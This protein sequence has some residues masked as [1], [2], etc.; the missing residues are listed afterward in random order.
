M[1][2]AL[3]DGDE[4][5]VC[6]GAGRWRSAR[7]G[8]AVEPTGEIVT[9]AR[10]APPITIAFAPVKGDRPEWVVQKLTELGV[11]TIVPL[12]AERSVVVWPRT[13]ESRTSSIACGGSAAKPRCSRGSAT[14][15][16][17]QRPCSF[18]DAV[19]RAGV[20]LAHR[21]AAAPDLAHPTVL[22]GPEGG[23]SDAE[24]AL[25]L[26]RVG[27]GPGVLA[28]GDR[29]GRGRRASGRPSIRPGARSRWVRSPSRSIAHRDRSSVW[30]P[31]NMGWSWAR[32][33]PGGEARAR[34][35]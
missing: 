32:A 30:W 28:R 31:K 26:P 18:A 6:D 21:G 20:C 25:G 23:W 13:I 5:T 14:S 17:W 16:R 35:D 24:L 19:R 1:C 7:F 11:D 9:V 3:R 33:S 27:L 15:P 2:S 34:H 8:D 29:R 22:V 10:A 4:I 12:V